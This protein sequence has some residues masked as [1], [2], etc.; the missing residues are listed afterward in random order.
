MFRKQ[1]SSRKNREQETEPSRILALKELSD[2]LLAGGYFRARIPTLSPFD[3]IVGGL[4]WSVTASGVSVDVDLIFQENSTIGERIKLSESI[5]TALIEMKCPFRLEPN[6]IQGL[7]YDNIFPVVRWLIKS[8]LENRRLTGDRVRQLAVSQFSRSYA[9]AGDQSEVGEKFICSVQDSYRPTRKFRKAGTADFSTL[10]QAVEASLLEYGEKISRVVED[11]EAEEKAAEKKAGRSGNKDAEERKQKAAEKRQRK[12]EAEERER[13]DELQSQLAAAGQEG[14]VSTQAVGNVI[15]MQAAEI[16]AMA[17]NYNEVIASQE[18]EE[19]ESSEGM[20]GKRT[21][22][23]QFQRQM[24]NMTKKYEARRA[25]LEEKKKIFQAASSK[26]A[27]VNAKLEAKESMKQ[28]I[29]HATEDMEA[30]EKNA[31]ADQKAILN[32][33]K[34]MVLLNENLKTQEKNFVENC[35]AQHEDLKRKI[36]EL[37]E[38]AGDADAET[39]KMLEIEKIH[40]TDKDKLN[41]IALALAKKNQEISVMQRQID[42][43]PTRAELLQF[44]RRFIELYDTQSDILSETRKYY[45]MDQHLN[46]SY[47]FMRQEC[48]L[49][50]SIIDGFPVA[51]RS[52]QGKEAY[53]TQVSG[54]L[55][56]VQKQKEHVDGG[57]DNE[58][59]TRDV[60]VQ[61]HSVLLE[62]QRAY[63]KAVKEFQ[64]ECGTN[65]QLVAGLEGLQKKIKMLQ[66]RQQQ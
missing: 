31:S 14:K 50:N 28:K 53:K 47:D 46:D 21:L 6:Q 57:Y 48:D 63:F 19:S 25:I 3:K 41:R 26:S 18:K 38:G 59:A 62:R 44:E 13:L 56:G 60:L 58:A 55:E 17:A 5:V 7:D 15:T 8:V 23:L 65:E 49:L 11:A 37:E 39:K 10:E 1:K 54:I 32:K 30:K 4:V 64:E 52:R 29:I 40:N 16:K 24:E 42:D 20:G 43:I 33:L 51:S 61:K 36:Q 34:S 12:A 2:I 45:T 22:A 35:K 66:Q 9:L 27:E